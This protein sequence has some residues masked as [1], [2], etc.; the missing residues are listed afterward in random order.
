MCYFIKLCKI[1]FEN[2]KFLLNPRILWILWSSLFVYFW[3]NKSLDEAERE[4]FYV[5]NRRCPDWITDYSVER[6][7]SH[8]HFLIWKD[9]FFF[10]L[11]FYL[12]FVFSS[13]FQQLACVSFFFFLL[14]LSIWLNYSNK[15][16][17]PFPSCGE[18]KKKKEKIERELLANRLFTP[19]QV[20]PT[21]RAQLCSLFHFEGRLS[22]ILQLPLLLL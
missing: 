16:I 14:F 22:S 1:Y 6:Q 11:S 18:S 12:L 9:F 8:F 3:K 5:P 21:F 4:S 17:W 10:S 2:K 20:T 13:F 15:R 19:Y 7:L